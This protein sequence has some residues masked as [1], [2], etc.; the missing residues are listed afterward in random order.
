MKYF[1]F[2]THLFLFHFYFILESFEKRCKGHETELEKLK[3]DR[4][5]FKIELDNVSEQLEKCEMDNAYLK[6]DKGKDNRYFL[7]YASYTI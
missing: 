6:Q 1:P 3:K 2:E 7:I 5:H 4:D